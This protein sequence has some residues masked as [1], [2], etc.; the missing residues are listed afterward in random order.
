MKFHMVLSGSAL[1]GHS[2]R[3][4]LIHG[5]SQGSGYALLGHISAASMYAELAHVAVRLSQTTH[6]YYYTPHDL[7]TLHDY[8]LDSYLPSYDTSYLLLLSTENFVAWKLQWD[9]T[10]EGTIDPTSPDQ[11]VQWL[12]RGEAWAHSREG[13]P[14]SG[15][16]PGHM[17]E[18]CCSSKSHHHGRDG[19]CFDASGESLLLTIHLSC[20]L[21]P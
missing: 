10:F 18:P 5:G 4:L 16:G 19:R 3:D 7:T 2:M 12:Y 21:S 17:N 20:V 15:G 13:S 11:P 1:R 8:I 9:Q 6:Y 14:H